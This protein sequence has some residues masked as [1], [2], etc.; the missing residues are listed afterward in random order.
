MPSTDR[1][2]ET[3]IFFLF[4]HAEETA[5]KIRKVSLKKGIRLVEMPEAFR[6]SEDF[7]EYLKHTKGAF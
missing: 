3:N 1:K 7:G 6:G 2:K 5:D 4:Q